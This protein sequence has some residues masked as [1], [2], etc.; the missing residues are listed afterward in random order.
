MEKKK[1]QND[2]N[3]L[4]SVIKI[5]EINKSSHWITHLKNSDYKN[6]DSQLCFGTFRKRNIPKQLIE[7][8]FQRVLYGN[9]IFS[10]KSYKIIKNVYEYCNRQI[11]NDAIRHIFTFDLLLKLNLKFNRIC[12][13]G[14]GKAS[15]L[16]SANKIFPNTQFFSINLPEVLINDYIILNK[17]KLFDN[18]EIKVIKSVNDYISN[19]DKLIIVPS[20]HKD[21]LYDKGI[22]LFI[23]IA[24]FQEM[25][26]TEIS[27]YLKIIKNNSSYFYCCNRIS[28]KLYDGEII[29]FKSYDWGDN[30]KTFFEEI[31]PWHKKFYKLRPPY[32]LKY[33]G[34]HIHKFI[35]YN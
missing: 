9:S 18:S 19:N 2:I 24:S 8:L 7:N 28:K 30:Y 5:S 23:N 11:E 4:E 20:I 12:V 3:F 25:S 27:N 33:D 1:F 31:C 15:F 6:I 16:S 29:K 22:D 34:Q 21:F 26:Y 35:K 10:S 17:F 13:I 14:D 32:F